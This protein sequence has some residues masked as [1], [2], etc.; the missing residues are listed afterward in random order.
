M[1]RP[2]LQAPCSLK[3]SGQQVNE[4]IKQLPTELRGIERCLDHHG[5]C[6]PRSKTDQ[7]LQLMVK[8]TSLRTPFSFGLPRCVF[9]SFHAYLLRQWVHLF[10]LLKLFLLYSADVRNRFLKSHAFRFL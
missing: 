1:E 6:T 8:E 5:L 10:M 3:T 4:N 9:L 2:G 7:T